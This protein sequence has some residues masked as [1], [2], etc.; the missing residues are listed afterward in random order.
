MV[1]LPKFIPQ[2]FLAK[3]IVDFDHPY[4]LAELNEI[5]NKSVICL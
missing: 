5:I 2:T 1:S 4:R 3:F